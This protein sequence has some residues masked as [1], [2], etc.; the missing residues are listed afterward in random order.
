[1]VKSSVYL[2]HFLNIFFIVYS[3]VSSQLSLTLRFLVLLDMLHLLPVTVPSPDK[4]ESCVRKGSRC[5]NECQ[6]KRV[7]PSAVVTPLEISYLFFC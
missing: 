4:W 7:D 5:K 3:Q 2:N 1:M 6:I